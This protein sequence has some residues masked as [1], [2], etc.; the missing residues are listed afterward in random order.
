MNLLA[1]E[2]VEQQIV[3][4]LREEGHQVLYITESNPGITDEKVLEKSNE[5]KALLITADKDF[6]EIVYRQKKVSSGVILLRLEGLSNEKKSEIVAQVIK[7]REQE[8]REA[9]V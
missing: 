7:K 2:D 8:F 1:D 3:Q 5:E 4:K 6:G 9:L